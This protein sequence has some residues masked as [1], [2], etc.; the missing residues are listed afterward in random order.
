MA[1]LELQ[2]NIDGIPLFKSSNVTLW[3]ILCLVK[4]IDLKDPFVVG[5][6]SGKDI[7]RNATEFLAEFVTETCHVLNDGLIINDVKYSVSIHC[8][9]CDA[10]VRAYL[11]GIKSH[12][13]YASCEKCTVHGVYAGK[14][15]FPVLD[16]PPMH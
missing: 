14:V 7:P 9:V 10:P 5:M 6:F 2:F 4:D 13:G 3:S 1:H 12:S 16:A 8:F 11:K 15:I